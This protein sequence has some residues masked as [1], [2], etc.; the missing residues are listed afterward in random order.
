[1]VNRA[2]TFRGCIQSQ[3]IRNAENDMQGYEKGMDWDRCLQD[4]C[5]GI[6]CFEEFPIEVVNIVQRNFSHVPQLAT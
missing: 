1:M 4:V 5:Q 3:G 6:L 2:A